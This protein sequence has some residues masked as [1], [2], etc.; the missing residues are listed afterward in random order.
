MLAKVLIHFAL[1]PN[2]RFSLDANKSQALVT[3][4]ICTCALLTSASLKSKVH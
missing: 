4:M 2:G 3:F 1:K